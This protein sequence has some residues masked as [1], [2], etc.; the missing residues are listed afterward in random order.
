MIMFI[1]FGLMSCVLTFTGVFIL[2]IRKLSVVSAAL[3]VLI[4]GI[5]YVLATKN[6]SAILMLFIGKYMLVNLLRLY[7]AR[8]H[9]VYLRGVAL[10]TALSLYVG[11]IW[12]LLVTFVVSAIS[13]QTIT[14]AWGIA[15]VQAVV[16]S[17]MLVTLMRTL[18]KSRITPVIEHVTD[19]HLPTLSVLIPARNEDMDLEQCLRS[20]IASDYP[21]L[22]IIVL[23][24]CSQDRRVADIVKE[25]A[26]GGVRFIPGEIPRDNWLAKNQAYD[27]L[28]H[29]ASG[30]WLLFIGVDVR[31]QPD[32]LRT[33][34]N[35][36]LATQQKM[37][38]IM[39]ERTHPSVA[40]SFFV[41]LRYVWQLAFPRRLF[42]YPPVLST[43][44]LIDKKT[45]FAA[46]GMPAVA[47]TIIPEGYF[48]RVLNKSHVYSFWRSCAAVKVES[49]KSTS[50]QYQTSIRTLY[51]SLR[52]RP[53]TVLLVTLCMLLFGVG[54]YIGVVLSFIYGW[55][56][57]SPFVLVVVLSVG[58]HVAIAAAVSPR[59]SFVAILN[60]PILLIQ[61]IYL[62]NL[63][64]YRY[65][66]SEINWKGR[67]ICAPVM[68]VTP[69]LPTVK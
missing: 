30:E 7:K 44:W 50:E 29:A 68:H 38:S 6:I 54:P 36:A 42:G 49:A 41:P 55:S 27:A 32:S 28:S 2:K 69:R 20:V 12:L 67:N 53:E 57:L 17:I 11:V 10:R 52:K 21:K 61:E 59:T 51:P 65:E 24:D 35:Q 23:D 15:G 46:G 40:A 4:A 19:D 37:V 48:S 63:S 3:S 66:F 56:A 60:L 13:P 33:V 22:E 64:M 18:Y 58:I 8:M 62:L 45:F 16:V 31:L 1:L 47:R 5:T 9:E 26:Q 43:A 34:V 14:L 39:P 25:L